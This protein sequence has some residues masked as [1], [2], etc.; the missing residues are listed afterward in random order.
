MHFSRP[1]YT[2]ALFLYSLEKRQMWALVA[3]SWINAAISKMQNLQLS[4]SDYKKGVSFEYSVRGA[5]SFDWG[6]LE[7]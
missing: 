4:K 1:L 5:V 2:V 3:L 7:E 6:D